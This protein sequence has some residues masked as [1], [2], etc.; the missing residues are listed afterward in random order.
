MPGDG[1]RPGEIPETGLPNLKELFPQEVEDLFSE[2]GLPRYRGRQVFRWIHK[3]QECSFHN[4]TDLPRDLRERLAV[5][6]DIHEAGVITRQ[7][8][9]DGTVKYL[10]GLRDGN[11]VEAACMRYRYGVTACVSSQVGCRMACKMCATGLSGF[12]R[13]LMVSEMLDQVFIMN[14]DV[15]R[16]GDRVRNVVMMGSGEPLDNYDNVIRFLRLLNE[17]A[18]LDI[19]FRRMTISTCGII[20]GIYRLAGEGLPVTLSV[21]LHAPNDELRDRIV[22][23]NRRY[24]ISPLLDACRAYIRASGRRVTFEYSL[25][26]GVNDSLSCARELGGILKGMLCHVNL[27]SFNPIEERSY[28]RPDPVVIKEFAAVL[29]GYGISVTIRRTLGSDIDAACGQLRRRYCASHI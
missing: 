20:P 29:K 3:K 12:K 14:R 28:E 11:A 24:P 13:S 17:P 23:V 8:S 16:K 1:H 9:R 27:I 26:R 2:M 18:G 19:G 22:P 21:S 6:F 25:I 10:L 15:S 4:M 7:E 5:V